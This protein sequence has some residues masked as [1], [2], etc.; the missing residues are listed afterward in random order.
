[1]W[2]PMNPAPP[3]TKTFMGIPFERRVQFNAIHGENNREVGLMIFRR[4]V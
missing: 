2:L 1:V 4:R 3:V